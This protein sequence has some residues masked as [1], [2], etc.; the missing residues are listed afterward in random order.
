MEPFTRSD[1]MLERDAFECAKMREYVAEATGKIYYAVRKQAVEQK[2]P[3][4]FHTIHGGMFNDVQGVA[5]TICEDL[6][7]LFPDFNI[8]IGVVNDGLKRGRYIA[9]RWCE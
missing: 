9:V 7:A 2:N 1:L 6:I 4:Y 3:E 5:E 8:D